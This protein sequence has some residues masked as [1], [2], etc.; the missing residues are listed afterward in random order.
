MTTT[1]LTDTQREVQ[2][3]AREFAREE[4][5]PHA[6][7]WNRRHHVP[8]DVLLRMGELGLLGIL[9]PEEH[10]GAGLDYTSLC[11]VVEEIAR[12]RRRHLDGDRRAERPGGLAAPARRH[13]GAARAL[14]P[15][16]RDRPALRAPTR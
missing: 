6:A 13:A 16:R 3:L 10:E 2:A 4:I 15:R 5:A 14:A 12:G 11:L 1:L 7:D 9:A 8:V